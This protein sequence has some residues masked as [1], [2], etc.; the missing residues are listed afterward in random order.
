MNSF[1]LSLRLFLVGIVL[2]SVLKSSVDAVET[3]RYTIESFSNVLSSFKDEQVELCATFGFAGERGNSL[4][5]AL[6]G[7]DSGLDLTAIYSN[8]PLSLAKLMLIERTVGF[9]HS[10]EILGYDVAISP[11][12]QTLI[13][14]AVVGGRKK[15]VVLV[16][17]TTKLRTVEKLKEE[18]AR[19][20]DVAGAA[21]QI[22]VG[23]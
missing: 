19:S 10:S 13:D 11:F 20:V 4:Y 6:F 14:S 1:F 17:E 22:E 7:E 16:L 21:K 3:S 8:S 2:F 9:F 18:I 12:V 5:D 23:A 15:K